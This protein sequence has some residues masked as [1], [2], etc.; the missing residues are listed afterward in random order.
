MVAVLL[1]S[2]GVLFAS[3]AP[4][5]LEKL[6]EKIGIADRARNFLRTPLAGYEVGSFRSP[7]FREA[8]AGLIGLVMI[9]GVCFGLAKVLARRRRT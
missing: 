8:A 2:I 4:D 5:G 9:L 7:W 1:A 3:A 6:A